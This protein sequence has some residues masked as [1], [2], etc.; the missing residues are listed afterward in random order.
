MCDFS[1]AAESEYRSKS[2]ESLV[3]QYF[4]RPAQRRGYSI[5]L[6]QLHGFK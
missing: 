3:P 6:L 2:P 1:D 4:W 5:I